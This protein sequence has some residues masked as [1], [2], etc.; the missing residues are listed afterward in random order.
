MITR[1]RDEDFTHFFENDHIITLHTKKH[2]NHLNHYDLGLDFFVAVLV[3]KATQTEANLDPLQPNPLPP[4]S[5][6]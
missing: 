4:R 1:Q 2:N 5:L 6:L 3:M